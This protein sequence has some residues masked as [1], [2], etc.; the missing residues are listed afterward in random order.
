[1]THPGGKKPRNGK[2]QRQRGDRFERECVHAFAEYCIR[3]VRVPLSGATAFQKG[4]VAIW[5]SFDP[6]GKPLIAECKRVKKLPVIFSKLADND[7]LIVREDNGE[8]MAVLPLYALAA[9]LQ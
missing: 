6:Q 4:D 8:A 3:A 9:L 2:G 7:L 1:M 5:P